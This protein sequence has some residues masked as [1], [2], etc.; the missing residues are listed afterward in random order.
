MSQTILIEPN[1]D[2]KKIFSLNLHTF[3]GTDVIHRHNSE[4]TVNLLAILPQIALI[5]TRAQVDKDSTAEKISKYL[6]EHNLDIPMIVMGNTE[7]VDK[8]SL[9]MPDPINWEI[10]IAHA[11]KFLGVTL[12]DVA[13]KIKPDYLPI[14]VYYF[15]DIVNTPCDVYI[16]IKKGT[17]DYQYV[18]RIHSKDTFDK[19]VIKKYEEQGLKE[20]YIPRDYQQYFINFLTNHLVKKLERDD[21]TLEDRILTTANTHE[22]VRDQ[23]RDLGLE[24][25]TVDLA[26]AGIESMIRSVKNS[27]EVTNLLKFLFTNKVSYAYQHCHLMTVM[28]HYI[29]SKQSWYKPDHLET[30]SFVSFFS[31][32]TLKSMSQMQICDTTD[33]NDTPLTDEERAHVMS[34]AKDAV[35]LIQNHP[36]VTDTMKHVLLQ[37]H[38]A[39][40]GIGFPEN[41]DEDIHPLAK[42]FII[43]DNFVKILLHPEK[44]KSKKEILPIMYKRFTN[45]SYQKIIK[46]LE[47]RFDA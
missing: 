27:P 36:E 43:A 16:R 29:L 8:S 4:D 5:I 9:V 15:Y 10:L 7:N 40:D 12:N 47:Q 39:V 38:G 6:K 28:C 1:D 35:E 23:V 33:L 25:S 2:L 34:H 22:I 31:D 30:L 26:D 44:P 19:E 32:V 37:H 24:E 41:P 20:F 13:K 14:G 42:V 3:V 11:A 46:A 17:G 18:K 45:P 21:L